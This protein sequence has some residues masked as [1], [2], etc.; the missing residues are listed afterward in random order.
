MSYFHEA[1]SITGFFQN[2]T[3]VKT[4]K[5]SLSFMEPNYLLWCSPGAYKWPHFEPDESIHIL[6]ICKVYFN[7]IL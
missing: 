1:E 7:I 6:T 3:V 5:D 2:L 4:V